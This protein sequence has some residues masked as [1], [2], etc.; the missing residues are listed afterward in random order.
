MT[1]FEQAH[2]KFI[3]LSDIKRAEPGTISIPVF[4]SSLILTLYSSHPNSHI[5]FF[6]HF[7]FDTSRICSRQFFNRHIPCVDQFNLIAASF[8]QLISSESRTEKSKIVKIVRMVI[9]LTQTRHI[10]VCLMIFISKFQ[11]SGAVRHILHYLF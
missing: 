9:L 3:L 4:R 10:P 6:R 7:N 11:W 2:A 8:R 5:L 1:Y